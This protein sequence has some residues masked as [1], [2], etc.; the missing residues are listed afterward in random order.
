MKTVFNSDMVAHTWAQLSQPH[1]R[2]SSN[3]MHFDGPLAYSYRTP[4]AHIVKGTDGTSVA[5]FTSRTYSI[6]ASSRHMPAYH[7]AARHLPYFKVPDVLSY[8]SSQTTPADHADNLA[9][10]RA[11]FDKESAALLRVPA[12]SWRVK[13]NHAHD[14]LASMSTIADS[15]CKAFGLPSLALDWNAAADAAIA[16]RDKLLSD[17]KRAAKI[18]AAAE[19]RARAEANKLELQRL[20]RIEQAQKQLAYI[21]EWRAHVFD[22][23]YRRVSDEHG[24]ALI[25]L[26]L[27]GQSFE[28]SWGVSDVDRLT[29]EGMIRAYFRGINLVGQQI[30]P[31]TV[32][33]QDANGF[34][35]QIGCHD[36][37]RAE[38]ERMRDSLATFARRWDSLV[39]E[40]RR[41]WLEG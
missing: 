37:S 34:A 36:F 7:R 3:S 16:R 30:G 22:A 39:A 38:L 15:Y 25:R 33:S 23:K 2:N 4:V 17:P 6:T 13:E 29:G 9:Y 18:A 21:P 40:E 19:A 24:G 26:S 28:T 14:T 27:D 8:A 35:L 41:I 11:E 32:R 1:G 20:A 12:D 10:F 5:L 31:F